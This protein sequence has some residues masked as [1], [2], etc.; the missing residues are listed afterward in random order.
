VLF[1]GFLIISPPPLS[2]VFRS[3]PLS[4]FPFFSW[5]LR[6][7][8]GLVIL[9]VG[10]G[11]EAPPTGSQFGLVTMKNSPPPIS[12]FF[13]HFSKCLDFSLRSLTKHCFSSAEE[14]GVFFLLPPDTDLWNLPFRVRGRYSFPLRGFPSDFCVKL[15][16]PRQYPK[17]RDLFFGSSFLLVSLLTVPPSFSCNCGSSP[18]EYSVWILSFQWNS[19]FFHPSKRPKQ[20]LSPQTLRSL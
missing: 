6:E 1:Y 7:L 18:N 11:L 2:L 10:S 12:S 19:L 14:T 16:I 15:A 20:L 9:A 4:S 17:H 13:F 3:R 5:S 8:V